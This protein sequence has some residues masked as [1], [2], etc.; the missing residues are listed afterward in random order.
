MQS[1]MNKFHAGAL[2]QLTA[3]I[4]NARNGETVSSA[5]REL[6]EYF[7]TLYKNANKGIKGRGKDV[8]VV[9]SAST[10]THASVMSMLGAR[11]GMNTVGMLASDLT[12]RL[13]VSSG[14]SAQHMKVEGREGSHGP[15]GYAVY[16]EDDDVSRRGSRSSS[17]SSSSIYDVDAS[18]D[19]YDTEGRELAFGDRIY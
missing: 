3:K 1:H 18:T 17:S 8:R 16:D 14:M 10:Y 9:G 4:A 2:Q 11:G 15:V 6:R 7:A 13:D 19:H 12:M 5:D